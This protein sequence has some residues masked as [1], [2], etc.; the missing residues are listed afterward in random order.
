MKPSYIL[1]KKIKPISIIAVILNLKCVRFCTTITNNITIN[2]GGTPSVTKCIN[3]KKM[4]HYCS[5]NG[6]I[7]II[8]II[9]IIIIIS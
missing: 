8:I 9:N 2:E 6:G 4:S 3:C 1:G 7:L 5:K